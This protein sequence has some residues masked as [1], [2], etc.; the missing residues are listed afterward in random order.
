MKKIGGERKSGYA[1]RISVSSFSY[2][3]EIPRDESGNG[4]GF[5]FD[6]RAI[7]NPGRID[8]LKNFTGRDLPVQ[9]FLGSQ[10]EVQKFLKEIFCIVDQSVEKYIQ[11]NFTNLMVNFGCTG[12]Q[13]RSVYCAETLAKQLKNKYNINVRL[14]H[15][16]QGK[17]W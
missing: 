14:T 16:E 9:K 4:G 5:V 2:R 10:S 15:T 1:L 12:G 6:C 11:N 8:E 3:K 7:P 13:H 17:R